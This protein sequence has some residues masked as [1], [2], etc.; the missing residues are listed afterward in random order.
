[1][2]VWKQRMGDLLAGVMQEARVSEQE[3]ARLGATIIALRGKQD[4]VIFVNVFPPEQGDDHAYVEHRAVLELCR[5]ETAWYMRQVLYPE[6]C[7]LDEAVLAYHKEGIRFEFDIH[8]HDLES[9]FHMY[10]D[11]VPPIVLRLRVPYDATPEDF[12]IADNEYR[13]LLGKYASKI[14]G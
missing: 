2:D 7:E 4:G 14:K 9:V 13:R 6:W 5:R 8:P 12:I 10:Y 1:M 3:N 11:V